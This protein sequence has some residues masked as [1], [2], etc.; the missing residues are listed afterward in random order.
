[1]IPSTLEIAVIIPAYNEAITI[2]QVMEDFHQH[3][4]EAAIY[5][6]DNNSS[7]DTARIARETYEVL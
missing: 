6:I 4:P 2:R 1:M 7:D 5:I 3:C